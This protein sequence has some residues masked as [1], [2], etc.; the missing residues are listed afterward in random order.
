MW[1]FQNGNSKK[2]LPRRLRTR[3]H[4]S[5][6]STDGLSSQG[7]GSKPIEWDSP[8]FIQEEELKR[9]YPATKA[10]ENPKKIQENKNCNPISKNFHNWDTPKFL[11]QPQIQERSAITLLPVPPRNKNSTAVLSDIDARTARLLGKDKP[12]MTDEEVK[13]LEIK[14]FGEIL[15][16]P[17]TEKMPVKSG[18]CTADELISEIMS[19]TA[20]VED[21]WVLNMSA[22]I[23]ALGGIKNDDGLAT[24]EKAQ[25]VINE[26]HGTC[27]LKP[28][29]PDDICESVRKTNKMTPEHEA[30]DEL[31]IQSAVEQMLL[32]AEKQHKPITN[33]E[34]K[35]IELESRSP[36]DLGQDPSHFRED[37]SALLEAVSSHAMQY[38]SQDDDSLLLNEAT[39]A[40]FHAKQKTDSDSESSSSSI[41][42]Y[43]SD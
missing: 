15:T 4:D 26:A 28:L 19:E 22:R 18:H 6:F 23:S 42:S 32:D 20:L 8:K 12:K 35:S 17:S 34:S 24:G 29:D 40:I 9:R 1:P 5:S 3:Y 37:I 13:C 16:D 30:D 33:R 41:E 7:K 10:H 27:T 11:K 38:K 2:G 14:V 25:N 21:E 31:K 39:D 36:K 43:T